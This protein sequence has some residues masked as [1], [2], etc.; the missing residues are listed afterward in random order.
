MNR[1]NDPRFFA[2][3]VH[4]GLLSAPLARD[5]MAADDPVDFL[6][7]GGH[8]TAEQWEV[9]EATEAGKRPQLT[10]YELGGLLG[11]GGMARVFEATDRSAGDI[12]ALK[13]LKPSLCKDATVVRRFIAESNLLIDL[14]CDHIVAAHRVAREGDAIYLEMELLEGRCLQDDLSEDTP[15]DELEAL[16]IVVQI[17]KALEYLHGRGL[18]HRDIKPGNIIQCSDGRA[19]LIDLGFAVGSDGDD[20]DLTSGTVHYISPE[21]ATGS[22][23]LDVRAD[24][25]SL[26]CTLYHLVTG[27][28]P[29]DGE[30]SEEVMARQ[31]L[32]TLSDERIKAIG[33]SQQAHFFIEKMMAKEKEIRFQDP[34]ELIAEIEGYLKSV[35]WEAEQDAAREKPKRG[36]TLRSQARGRPTR[37]R[38]GRR[39]PR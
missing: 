10:R 13:V 6:I 19:V 31:V 22:G 26:G 36:S 16:S 38:T 32:D 18:V 21:Q 28:L 11:E 27:S 25:Y 1:R 5:A 9:W 34:A 24:I 35:A 29:F 30:S 37:R 12:S 33:L 3:L 14:K 17:A 15:M 2:L 4:E 23:Q 8:V 39:R 20:S 7:A